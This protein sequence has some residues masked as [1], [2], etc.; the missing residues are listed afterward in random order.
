M[1]K[2]GNQIVHCLIWLPNN[3]MEI[4][5][6]PK[7]GMEKSGMVKF[8]ISIFWKFQIMEWK[9][10]DF[11]FLE[12]PK[13]GISAPVCGRAREDVHKPSFNIKNCLPLF[14]VENELRFASVRYPEIQTV[15]L[16]KPWP[17]RARAGL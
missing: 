9:K 13:N 2:S 7:N 14:V 4:F 15:W 10:L 6:I 3:G 17:A 16:T 12:I 8:G 11:H 1:V 5:I